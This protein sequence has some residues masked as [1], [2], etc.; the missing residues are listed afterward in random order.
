MAVKRVL[1]A[2]PHGFCAGVR[3]AVEI[4]ETALTVC[5]P[6]L[7]CLNP[8]VHNRQVV[9]DL[10]RR[11]VRFIRDLNDVPRGAVVLFSAHGVPPATRRLAEARDLQVLDATCPYVTRLHADVRRYARA[12]CRVLLIGHPDHDE[13][14]GVRGEAPER[15][16]VLTTADDARRVPLDPA[17][18]VAV[19]TQTTLSVE[20]TDAVLGI[21]KA[22]CP[23]LHAASGGTICH[24]THN[25]QRAVRA[26]AAEADRVLVLGSSGSSNSRRL[27][28]VAR[29]AG[30]PAQLVETPDNLESLPLDR[31]GVLG[32]TA[33]AS[34]PESFVQAVLERLRSAGFNRVEDRVAVAESVRFPLPRAL[35]ALRARRLPG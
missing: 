7:F 30:V 18:R 25:R 27:I 11:G 32:L 20:D 33:G 4:V 29:A 13:I 19:A 14:V 16:T 35:L 3:H 26:I 31:V 17:D 22:R 2:H 15:I 9:D 5:P 28:E 12:G 10:A 21:L 1:V 34:T 8:L 6:P 24:A 23:A